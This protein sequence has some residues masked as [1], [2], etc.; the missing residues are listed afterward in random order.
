MDEITQKKRKIAKRAGDLIIEIDSLEKTVKSIQ[1]K[2]D[3]KEGLTVKVF[4]DYHGS[5]ELKS[6]DLEG[7]GGNELHLSILKYVESQ[8]KKRADELDELIKILV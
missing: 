1:R 2:I 7:I 3:C 6:R 8:I 5:S 4:D